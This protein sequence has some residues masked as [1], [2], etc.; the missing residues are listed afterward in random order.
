MSLSSGAHCIGN[1][2]KSPACHAPIQNINL[3][4]NIYGGSQVAPQLQY[5]IVTN[6]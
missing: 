3:K 2:F 1:E 4:Q 5:P 6:D